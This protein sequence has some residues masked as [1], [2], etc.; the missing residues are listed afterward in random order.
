[1]A[2]KR[3]TRKRKKGRNLYFNSDTCAAIVEYQESD[4]KAEREKIFVSR[5]HPAYDKLVENLI[6]IHRFAGQYDTHDDLKNDCVAYLYESI[7][8]FDPSRGTNAFSYFNI[9][10]KHWLIIRSK[11]RIQRI[12]RNV[13]LDN[14][15]A[16]TRLDIATIEQHA[17]VP[18]ADEIMMAE[19]K[20]NSI[21]ALFDEIKS[22]LKNHNEMIVMDA[23]ISL[24]KMANDLDLL[25]KSATLMYIREMTGLTPKQLTMTMYSIKKH[26]RELWR[27]ERFGMFS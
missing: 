27:D 8:K 19:E 24:F 3:V 25:N 14:S 21:L 12:K 16:F 5:I 15:E 23:I 2:Q 17:I 22:Q 18:P 6:N 7:H 4:S 9:V 1:M 26:F 11:K 13:S 20:R 10:A